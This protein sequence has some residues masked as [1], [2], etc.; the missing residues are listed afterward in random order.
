MGTAA[1][2]VPFSAKQHADA[3]AV[4]QGA[5][6]RHHALDMAI[7]EFAAAIA[8]DQRQPAGQA[9]IGF[10]RTWPLMRVQFRLALQQQQQIGQRRFAG[11]R[12]RCGHARASTKARSSGVSMVK[13]PP[14]RASGG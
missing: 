9:R 11:P 10:C 4:A 8:A 5:R 14:L 1:S 2:S 13:R 7:A 6:Q 3:F 12:L